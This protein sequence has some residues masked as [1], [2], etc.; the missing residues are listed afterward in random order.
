MGAHPA[1]SDSPIAVLASLKVSSR[2][3]CM[4][5]KGEGKYTR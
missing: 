1:S 4:H 3:L 5:S 2:Y